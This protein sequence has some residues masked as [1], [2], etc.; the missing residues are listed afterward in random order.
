MSLKYFWCAARPA[1]T[2]VPTGIPRLRGCPT[3]MP[4]EL[5]PFRLG[6]GELHRCLLASVPVLLPGLSAARFKLLALL[7]TQ[8][9]PLN[10]S[11]FIST[12]FASVWKL[13][14]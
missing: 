8:T 10:F 2:R 1:G 13:K 12:Y 5:P 11:G 14:S 6:V 4:G 7:P 9:F 3:W